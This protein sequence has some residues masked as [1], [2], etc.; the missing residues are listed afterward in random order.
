MRERDERLCPL[1]KNENKNKEKSV[2][3]MDEKEEEEG[4]KYSYGVMY[5]LSS[6][7]LWCLYDQANETVGWFHAWLEHFFFFS[8][9]R[10]YGLLM[11]YLIDK[12]CW[13]YEANDDT[14]RWWWCVHESIERALI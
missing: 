4:M 6:S 10:A 7:H 2:P 14:I 5:L 1:S 3:S 12:A 9:G 13:H 8:F 11:Q